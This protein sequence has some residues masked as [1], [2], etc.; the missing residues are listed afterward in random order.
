MWKIGESSGLKIIIG[1]AFT[2]RMYVCR[3]QFFGM[4]GGDLSGLNGM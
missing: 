1:S 2:D 4:N 3:F